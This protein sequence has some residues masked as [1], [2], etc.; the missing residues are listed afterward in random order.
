[1]KVP[2]IAENQNPWWDNPSHRATQFQQRRNLQKEISK[3]IS[4]FEDRRALMI[5]GPRQVG[6][7]VMLLQIVDDLA[8]EGF[9]L[10]NVLYFDFSDDRLL[11]VPAARE[12]LDSLHPNRD[13]NLPVILLLDEITEAHAWDRFLKQA[14]D[15]GQY[16]VIATDSSASLLRDGSR[17]S[18]L[19]RWD[20]YQIGGLTCREYLL[21]SSLPGTEPDEALRAQPSLYSDYLELGGFPEHVGNKDLLEVR[22]KIRSD[23]ADKAVLRDLL[24][25]NVDVGRARSVFIYLVQNSGSILSDTMISNRVEASSET[26]SRWIALLEDTQLIHRIHRFGSSPASQLSSRPKYYAADHGLVHAFGLSRS[27]DST[28]RAKVYECLCYRHLR[29]LLQEASQKGECRISYF[30]I[31]SGL[32]CDFIFSLD[33]RNLAIEV[34]S[35]ANVS[36]RKIKRLMR[37]ADQVG[38]EH[39]ILIY[40]GTVPQV[41]DSVHL[42]PLREFLLQPDSILEFMQ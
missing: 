24:R 21:L 1:M 18:G 35:S 8:S 36:E 33:D 37:V 15:S 3:R 12:V 31:P 4:D 7:T 42:L 10:T 6:K 26:V 25:H 28:G 22:R 39:Q 30:R 32:E 13:P 5:L 41:N 23:I 29:E 40:G 27:D 19:G 16:R 9:P 11:D 38:S 2:E 17:E 14:V 34:T 20:E